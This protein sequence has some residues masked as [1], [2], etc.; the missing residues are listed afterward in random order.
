MHLWWKR[1]TVESDPLCHESVSARLVPWDEKGLLFVLSLSLLFATIIKCLC[2]NELRKTV[3]V[4]TCYFFSKKFCGPEDTLL[5][6]KLAITDFP[7]LCIKLR[8]ASFNSISPMVFPYRAPRMVCSHRVTVA[9]SIR[10]IAI[11]IAER[12]DG[13]I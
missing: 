2:L 13:T 3:L 5:L 4:V 11:S 10:D 8:H 9:H 12:G 6:T 7:A 1:G